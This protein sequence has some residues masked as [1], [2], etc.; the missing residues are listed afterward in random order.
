VRTLRPVLG[1]PFPEAQLAAEFGTV[2][3]HPG[4]YTFVVTDYAFEDLL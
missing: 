2:R 3:T 4:F 1:Q